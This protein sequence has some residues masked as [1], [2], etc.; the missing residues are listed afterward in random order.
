[1]SENR[2]LKVDVDCT[3]MAKLIQSKFELC[4]YFVTHHTGWGLERIQGSYVLTGEWGKSEFRG[5]IGEGHPVI[6]P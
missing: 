4:P 5:C 3:R 1:M 6:R 2:E